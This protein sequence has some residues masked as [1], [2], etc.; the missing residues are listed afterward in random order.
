[1]KPGV[2][3]RIP[4][5]LAVLALLA[6]A[7][8]APAATPPTGGTEAPERPRVSTATDGIFTVSVPSDV[9]LR[10]TA[11]FRGS[12]PAAAAGRTVTLERFDEA[13]GI[14]LPVSATT[15]QEGGAFVAP[16][17]ADRPGAQ[18]L[19]ARLEAHGASS[20]SASPELGLTVYRRQMATW[21]GPGLYGRR[22][23]CGQRM[24]RRLQGV[25][26]KR[27]PCGTRVALLHR[28]RTVVVPVVD[29]GP[30]RRRTRWDLTAA[31]AAALG[32]TATAR[33]G[34]L[35]VPGPARR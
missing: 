32:F 33:V 4:M 15:V 30:F 9:L 24:T 26:H 20:S 12:V 13:T 22:T 3:A 23:A 2:R 16:W 11:G 35:R 34:A 18:R 17:K 29:R 31:T 28:G 19:R 14:W 27:L 21:Y 5:S 8:P 6:A 7:A 10:R 25:A 1:M